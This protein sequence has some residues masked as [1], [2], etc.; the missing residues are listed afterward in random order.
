MTPALT[1]LVGEMLTQARADPCPTLPQP[2]P[3]F[4]GGTCLVTWNDFQCTCPDNFTGPTCGTVSRA[5]DLWR[6]QDFG[7]REQHRQGS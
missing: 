5:S 3:C 2:N 4:N 6:P 7:S 1:A